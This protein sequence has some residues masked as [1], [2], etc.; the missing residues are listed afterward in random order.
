MNAFRIVTALADRWAKVRGRVAAFLTATVFVLV[1]AGIAVLV[2]LVLDMPL[3][4]AAL[5][6]GIWGLLSGLLALLVGQ[7]I[8]YRKAEQVVRHLHEDTTEGDEPR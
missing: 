6:G 4:M 5:G 3:W 2:A 8:A 1:V 7:I